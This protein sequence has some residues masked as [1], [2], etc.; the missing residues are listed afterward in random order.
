MMREILFRGKRDKRYDKE[1]D[2]VYGVPYIDNEAIVL[3][4][5]I[6]RGVLFSLKQSDNTQA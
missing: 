2:W 4:L 1:Q 5:M 3:W 6:V